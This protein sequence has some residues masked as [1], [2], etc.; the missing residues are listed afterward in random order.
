MTIP[1]AG[2]L[3]YFFWKQPEGWDWAFLLLIGILSQLAQ[4]FMTISYQNANLA[5]VSNLNYIGIIFALGFGFILFDETYN[6]FTYGGM[7]L[8]LSGVI[9]NFLYARSP[10]SK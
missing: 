2:V 7:L 3:S 9:L 6:L 4:Y 8:V 10:K 1:I 5:K